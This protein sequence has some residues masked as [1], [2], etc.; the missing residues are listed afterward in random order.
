MEPNFSTGSD[1]NSLRDAVKPLLSTNG[2]RWTLANEGE[3]LERSF[4][5]KTFTKTW[6]SSLA[7]IFTPPHISISIIHPN[8]TR[9]MKRQPPMQYDV[10]LSVARRE[11]VHLPAL[12]VQSDSDLK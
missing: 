11:C 5:F 10:Y 6:V 2:G 4:K 8:A 3:A 1:I 7:F 12:R 9:L